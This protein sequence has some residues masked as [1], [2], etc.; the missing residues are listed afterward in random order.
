MLYS[1]QREAIL[2]MKSTGKS[3]LKNFK[4]LYEE[5]AAS[6][7]MFAKRFIPTDAAEDVVH[8]VFLEVWNLSG[9][10]EDLPTYAYLFKAVRN[11]CLNKLKREQVKDQYIQSTQ[12]DNQLLGLDFYQSHEKLLIDKEGLQLLHDQI[13]ALPEKCRIIFKM[14]YFEEKKNAEIAEILSLSIRTVEHQLYLGLKT[15]REKLTAKGKRSLFFMIF[16]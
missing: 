4:A 11:R 3:H 9:E 7:L 10:K 2:F 6:L 13:E 14:S 8:D 5:N 12:I 16:L 1:Q 15:L